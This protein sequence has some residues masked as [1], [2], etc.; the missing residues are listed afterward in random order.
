MRVIAG[1]AR[2]RT[3]RAPKGMAVRPTSDRVREA[4]FSSLAPVIPEAQVLDLFA[5][6]GA[7]G[8]EALS[9]GASHA[10]FVERDPVTADILRTNLS[11][12]GLAD[13]ATVVRSAAVVFA[14]RHHL[15]PFTL[16]LCDPP[17]D[18]PLGGLLDV[19][20]ALDAGGGLAA[21][22]TVVVERDKRDPALDGELELRGLLAIDRRRAYG[23]TVLLYLR[24]PGDA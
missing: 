9:R 19:L 1:T 7:L 18:L 22:A 13:R 15:A 23:D 11:A 16:V 17:Y 10:T 3:L 21:H 4:M 24:R 20:E 5:G 12:T 14:G 6:T 8:I 2:G